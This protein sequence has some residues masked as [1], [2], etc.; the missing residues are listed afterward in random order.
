MTVRPTG[1]VASRALPLPR[2]L[3][4]AVAC[5]EGDW[6]YEWPATDDPFVGLVIDVRP[7]YRALRG[8]LP[9]AADVVVLRCE[10]PSDSLPEL[11]DAM[12]DMP[13]PAIVTSPRRD[14]TAV[15]EV[16]RLGGGYLVEGDYSPCM[17]SVAV[18]NAMNG[19]TH[20]SSVACSALREGARRM[21]F[22]Q[23]GARDAPP[24]PLSRRERQIMELLSTGVGV[25]EIGPRLGLSERTVRNYLSNVYAKLGARNS[26]EAVL[27]RHGASLRGA[28]DEAAAM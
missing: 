17:L 16:F 18:M 14:I 5:A 2:R 13:A 19:H 10:D 28:D 6:S 1:W 27:R 11:L 21:T 26:T 8:G 15:M 22:P 4:V 25:Q 9:A 24:A 3:T 12:G 23:A 20:L 7:P